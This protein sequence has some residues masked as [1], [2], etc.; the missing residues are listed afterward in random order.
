VKRKREKRRSA[1]ASD[2]PDVPAHDELDALAQRFTRFADEART[3][4]GPLYEELSLQI[5]A[6]EDLLAVARHVR[7]PPI[8]NVFFAAVH[9]LLAEKPEHDLSMFY[10][11]VCDDPRPASDAGPAFRDF[12]LSNTDSLIPLLE[13]RITQTNEVA[14]C[15]YLLPAFVVAHQSAG[16]RPLALI[17]VGCS[18]G[19]H[20]NWDR[21]HY[22]YG[23][24]QVGDPRSAVSIRCELRGPVRP[25]LPATFPEC[26]FRLGID[27][28]PVDV[29]NPT[30]RRWFEALIWP[31]HPARRR[32]AAAAIEE[33]LRNPPALVKGDAVDVLGEQLKLVPP[34]TSLVVYNSAALCQGGEVDQQAIRQVLSAFS[35]RRPLHWLHCESL[36]MLH[37][38]ID[39]GRIVETKLANIDG[40]GRWLEW[41]AGEERM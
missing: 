32:L 4:E 1:P 16:G 12:V 26:R 19:L 18:A 28:N 7:R 21:Y 36:E 20:L 14:R 41:L 30:E 6:D 10:G 5:A 22:D 15:S 27:L 17:D 33:L 8:P 34:E 38:A 23:V 24:A 9:F 39:A 25:P 35:S 29:R 3:Y 11:S 2:S 37:R 40:H 13:T 31:D